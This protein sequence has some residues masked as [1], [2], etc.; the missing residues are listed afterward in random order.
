[1]LSKERVDRMFYSHV[2][3]LHANQGQSKALQFSTREERNVTVLHLFEFCSSRQR[4][5]KSFYQRKISLTKD[6]HNAVHVVHLRTGLNQR[7]DLLH[8]SLD[9]SRDLVNILGLDNSLQIVFQHFRE[10]IWKAVSVVP[11]NPIPR[12]TYSEVQIHGSI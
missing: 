9:S 7:A 3:L 5:L 6:I 11:N 10:V 1:M 4:M 12:S 8:G 2:R